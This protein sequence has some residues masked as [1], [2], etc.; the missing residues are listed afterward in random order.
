MKSDAIIGAVQGVTKKW[1]KQ[2]KAEERK[3]SASLNR[4]YV[5]T[6][7]Y[8]VSIKE[9]AWEIM[10]QAYLKASANGTLPAHARQIMY[11]ARGHIQRTADKAIGKG[12]DQYFTQTLL[13]G[14]IEEMGV[15]WNV[16]FDARGHFREPHTGQEV[17]LGTLQVR[18]YLGDVRRHFV[19][20]LNFDIGEGGFPTTGPK[21]RYGAIMFIEKEG[22]MPL[23]EEVKLA[24]RYDIAIMSTKGM[25]VTASREL[26]DTI[27]ADHDI[28]L[29][30]IHDFDKSGFS[31]AGTLRRN[32]RRYTFSNDIEV[33][34]VGLRIEDIDGLETEDV[35]LKSTWAA[36]EN[37]RENGAT[38]E[39]IEFLLHHRVE[40]NAFASDELVAWIEKKLKEHGVNKVV[41]D[42][43]TLIDAFRR[44]RRQAVVQARI[45]EVLEELGDDDPE[46]E[47]PIGLRAKVEQC[48][49][50]DPA[51]SWDAVVKEIAE[52]D[53]DK[54][55]RNG[56]AS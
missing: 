29:L 37:L 4:R 41:P 14:Y 1:S 12:F 33:I 13:P 47:D 18:N 5:M 16:V 48:L 7:R 34:D 39:E 8:H 38:E 25:S 27:C 46:D 15:D 20:D 19:G 52:A 49:Q 55:W 40:L 31:I 44:A 2:R 3:A 10:E 9:A 50:E 36:K 45:D 30:V 35:Y 56:D 54:A 28:P 53:H 6:R 51:R 26:V 11:A 23:F 43:D 24:E 22:F 17:P 32:T 21:N 42:E